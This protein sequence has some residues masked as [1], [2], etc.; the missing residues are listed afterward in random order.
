M[1][2]LARYS[3]CLMLA[4]AGIAL[5]KS[6]SEEL[7]LVLVATSDSPL[8]ALEI[9]QAR[10]I[11]LGGTLKVDDHQLQAIINFSDTELE[12]AFLQRVLFMSK[13][14]YQRR[15]T[16]LQFRSGSPVPPQINRSEDVLALLAEE[17]YRVSFV[18]ESQAETEPSLKVLAEF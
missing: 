5:S 13:E 3:F 15:L 7:K 16:K 8:N 2:R 4:V 1:K 14:L 18:W 9:Q 12:Q 6:Y 10:R 11:Y 17:K